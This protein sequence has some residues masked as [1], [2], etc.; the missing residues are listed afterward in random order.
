MLLTVAEIREQ[1][2]RQCGRCDFGLIEFG[3]NCPPG[4]ARW[5]IQMLCDE[6]DSLRQ[7]CRDVRRAAEQDPCQPQTVSDILRIVQPRHCG[8]DET[9]KRD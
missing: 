5:V 1:Y 4:D 3:C 2:L 8:V 6:V 9:P 7:V